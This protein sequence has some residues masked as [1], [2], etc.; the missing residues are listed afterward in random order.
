MDTII[1]QG[2]KGFYVVDCLKIFFCEDL[3]FF[4]FNAWHIYFNG[5]VQVN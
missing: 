1:S 3:G 5:Y 2:A 4:A